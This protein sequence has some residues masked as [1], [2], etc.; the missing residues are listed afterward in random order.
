MAEN[1]VGLSSLQI[2]ATAQN[3]GARTNSFTQPI[4]SNTQYTFSFY[5]KAATSF[6]GFAAGYSNNGSTK[7]ACTL[8]STTVIAGGWSRH[9]CTFTTGTVSG[10][11]F[12]YINQTNNVTRTF[13]I[14][15]VQLTQGAT[16]TPYQIGGVQVRGIFQE[17]AAFMSFSNSTNAFQIQNSTATNNLFIADTVNNFIGINT[18]SAA[19][20]LDVNGQIN[21][22][23]GFRFN[24]TAGQTVTCG[25]NQYLNQVVVQGGIVT[26]SNGCNGVGLSDQRLKTNVVALDGEIL[27]RMRSVRAVAFDFDCTNEYFDQTNTYCDTDRQAGVLAQELA[28]IFP[29]LVTQNENGFFEVDY[30]GLSVY[31]LRATAELAQYIDADGNANLKN[32]SVE[33][34]IAFDAVMSPALISKGAL[35][36]DASKD[37]TVAIGKDSG[38]V[39]LAEVG[40]QTTVKGALI[41]DGETQLNGAIKG[42]A[43]VIDTPNFNLDGSGN[44][45]SNGSITTKGGSVQILAADGKQL[46]R[47]G[48][49]GADFSGHLNI[50]TVTVNG[51]L[52]VNGDTTFAGLTT[53]QKLAVFIGTTVFRQ[54]VTFESHITVANDT[55]GY[56]QFKPGQTT[57]HV[58]FAREYATKPVVSLTTDG[59]KFTSYAVNN[60]TTK[61]FDVVLQTPSTEEL[62]LNWVVFGVNAPRTATGPEVV[63]AQP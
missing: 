32:L 42:G 46:V 15:S 48:Q 58:E 10:S 17:P 55:A 33:G 27:N 14:D 38:A 23:T 19:Y 22:S 41:V 57:V 7:T 52:T 36:I 44:L 45:T 1:H 63:T 47:I 12:V 9:S 2:N 37:A 29:D 53:F 6:T 62:Q 39:S 60:V 35:V 11:P 8:T 13:F 21:A 5:A 34:S 26:G 25:N 54:D 59:G 31:N 51:A 20:A 56:V 49:D 61:G 30:Q 18:A 4:T 28:Q 40:T 24:G 3:A 43:L 16:V 50:A